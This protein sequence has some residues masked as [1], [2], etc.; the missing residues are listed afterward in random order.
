VLKETDVGFLRKTVHPTFPAK[1]P[2]PRDEIVQCAL[3]Q[4]S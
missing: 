2:V 1:K 3:V 4:K